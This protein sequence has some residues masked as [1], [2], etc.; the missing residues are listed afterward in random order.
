MSS[1]YYEFSEFNWMYFARTP[2]IC[3]FLK[4][5][6]TH[7]TSNETPHNF[8]TLYSRFFPVENEKL[9]FPN[10]VFYFFLDRSLFTSGVTKPNKFIIISIVPRFQRWARSCPCVLCMCSYQDLRFSGQLSPGIQCYV[11]CWFERMPLWQA[12]CNG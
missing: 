12:R 10:V 8:H 11:L 3:H 9:Q 5:N 7:S 1:I 2:W 6:K 4:T